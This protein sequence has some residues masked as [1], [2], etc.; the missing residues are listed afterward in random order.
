MS[1]RRIRTAKYAKYAK[2]G[3]N[4]KLLRHLS[5]LPPLFVFVRVFRIFRGQILSLTSSLD[6][7]VSIAPIPSLEIELAAR[8]SWNEHPIVTGYDSSRALNR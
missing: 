3:Q 2:R 1:E 5:F 7:P 6:R 8:S 4:I